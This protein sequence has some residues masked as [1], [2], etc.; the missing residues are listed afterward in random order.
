MRAGRKK[1]SLIFFALLFADISESDA[2]DHGK[3]RILIYFI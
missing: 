2:V 3:F 1:N